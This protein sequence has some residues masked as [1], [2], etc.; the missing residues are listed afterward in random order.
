MIPRGI[1]RP[2]PRIRAREP[3]LRETGKDCPISSETLRP[4]MAM[5]SPKSPLVRMF[6]PVVEILNGARVYRDRSRLP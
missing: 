4:F 6:F 1:P 2:M 5:E 3:S